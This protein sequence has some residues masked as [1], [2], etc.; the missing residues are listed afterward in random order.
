[1]KRT[2]IAALLGTSMLVVPAA[3]LAKEVVKTEQAASA[4]Q[5]NY[6]K[7]M[8]LSDDG[9]TA[10]RDVRSARVAIF[11]GNPDQA[12]KSVEAA[13]K[14]IGKASADAKNYVGRTNGSK[15]S[16]EWIPIDGNIDIADNFVLDAKKGEHVT[17]ARTILRESPWPRASR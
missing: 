11:N 16:D 7:L 6:D 1:M 9:F 4:E 17:K 10:L 8:K 2:L 3:V 15:G 5:A 13:T 14:D 12:S